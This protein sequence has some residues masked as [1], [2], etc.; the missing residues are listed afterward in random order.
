MKIGPDTGTASPNVIGNV[1]GGGA[2]VKTHGYSALTRG[3]T[4]VTVQSEAQ[5]GHNVYGG[6]Q[7]AAVGKYYLGTEENQSQHPG[8]S[9]G[10]PYSLVDE[11]LGICNVTVKGAAT[12][13]GSV[14]GGGKGKDPENL[15]FAKPEGTAASNYHTESYEINSHMPK[16]MMNDYA[17]KNTYWEY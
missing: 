11:G 13:T 1:F 15:D 3:N 4:Y 16:R 12:I 6:G 8:L 14:F 2:G 17:G 5:V 7:I 10:M 9:V